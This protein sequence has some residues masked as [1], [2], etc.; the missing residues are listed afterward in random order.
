ME[1]NKNLTWEEFISARIPHRPEVDELALL[2]RLERPQGRVDVVMDTDTY[3]EID[4][5][6]ALSYMVKSPDKLNV[7]AIYAAPFFN[8][9]SV[10]PK[11]GMEKSYNEIIKVLTLLGREE[12]FPMVFKGADCFMTAETEP[13]CSAAAKD[14]A[15]RAMEYT[16]DAP[17]YVIA[18]G[19]ITN[20]ASAL[21][22]EPN[23]RDRIVIVW[24]GGNARHWPETREFNMLQDV[25]AARVVFNSGCA[26]V[27]LPCMGVV[28]AFT[29]T[30]PE[31]AYHLRGKNAL[32]DYLVDV[33][34]REGESSGCKTWSRTIWDVT[35]VAW[36]LNDDFTRSAI[37]HIPLPGYDDCYSFDSTRHF[38]RVVY[39]IDRDRVFEDLFRKLAE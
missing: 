39:H 36:L 23:I 24:L 26:V 22:I 31:L 20:V 18:L 1:E 38:Y 35:T 27:Q 11:D 37:E 15:K 29:T 33:T 7:K 16:P 14:L 4:D 17:L 2:R 12:L 25:A 34:T 3:N 19:A 5:Q 8:T 28:S 10:G 6:F 21:L 13:V 9:K 30:G 32:C